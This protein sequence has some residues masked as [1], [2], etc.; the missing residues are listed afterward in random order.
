M[1]VALH[2]NE[3]HRKFP[4]RKIHFVVGENET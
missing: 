3:F 1:D 4:F 2:F